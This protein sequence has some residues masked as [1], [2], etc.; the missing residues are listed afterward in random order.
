MIYDPELTSLDREGN[1]HYLAVESAKDHPDVP[2]LLAWSPKSAP[3]VGALRAIHRD[4]PA[5]HV[6]SSDPTK[7][8][9]QVR[10]LLLAQT[11]PF[12]ATT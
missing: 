9:R 12:E 10:E 2:M 6:A 8:L 1:S 3:E 7:L 4:A 5:V 11:Y